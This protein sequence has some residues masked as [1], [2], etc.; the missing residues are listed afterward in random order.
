VTCSVPEVGAAVPRRGGPQRIPRPPG[1]RVGGPPPWAALPD[2]ARRPSLGQIR[3]ALAA[4]LRP[5]RS[6]VEIVSHRFSAV[7]APLYEHDGEV[8]VVLT[9]RAWHMR[10]HTGEVAFPGG[11]QE[12]GESLWE[13]A[14]RESH[15]EV[16]LDPGTV[17]QVGELHHL[18]TVTSRASIVP[19]VGVLPGRPRLHP[20]PDEVDAVLHVSLADLLHPD[21]YREERWGVPG[22]DRPIHFFEIPGDTI[23]GATGAML[24]DLLTRLTGHATK[25]GPREG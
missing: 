13:T 10:S 19:F 21:T 16:A 25:D 15:E 12:P 23:W 22:L 1:T 17:E 2:E 20:N 7:L 8:H 6:P 18:A 11:K 24:H 9:R 4:G 3:D 14:L 5:R